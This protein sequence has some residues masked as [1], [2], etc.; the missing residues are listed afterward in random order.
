MNLEEE[1]GLCKLQI[2]SYAAHLS[3]ICQSFD[4][5]IAKI[6]VPLKT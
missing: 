4:V 6:F 1:K 5:M 2:C 3:L